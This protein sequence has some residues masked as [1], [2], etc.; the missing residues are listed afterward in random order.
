MGVEKA[1]ATG[2]FEYDLQN[3]DNI[4]EKYFTLRKNISKKIDTLKLL[5]SENVQ[6][7]KLESGQAKKFNDY[8]SMYITA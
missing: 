5:E 4:K 6:F 1:N 2:D 7:R 8:K 3:T